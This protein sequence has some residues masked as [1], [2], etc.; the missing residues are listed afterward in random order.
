M[1]LD[2]NF[3][4]R[5]V[6]KTIAALRISDHKSVCKYGIL[7]DS[8]VCEN[9]LLNLQVLKMAPTNVSIGNYVKL[10]N[11]AE[12]SGNARSKLR[13]LQNHKKARFR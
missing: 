6:G 8:K 11:S 13:F 2:F 9:F 3:P 5:L 4:F 1:I 7:T 12:A 10:R